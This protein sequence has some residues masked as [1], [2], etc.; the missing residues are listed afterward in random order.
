MH[1]APLLLLLTPSELAMILA[2]SVRCNKRPFDRPFARIG[3]VV[4]SSWQRWRPI[5]GDAFATRCF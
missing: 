1:G 4:I 3:V 2:L 5:I